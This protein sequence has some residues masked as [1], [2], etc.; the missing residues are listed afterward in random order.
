MTDNEYKLH[1]TM[2]AAM[3]SPLIM[4]N[5]VT[6][7]DAATY[8]I[9]TNP[10]ILAI[11]QDPLGATI[12]RR[13]RYFVPHQDT[14]GVGEI[15]M[16]AG[17]LANGDWVVVLINAATC[18]Y[19]M[20]ATA[21]D[22]FIDNGGAKSTEAMSNWDVYDLWANRMPPAVAN[23]ILNANS[24]VNI[25]NVDTYLYNATAMSYADGIM[26]NHTTLMGKMVSRGPSLQLFDRRS[27]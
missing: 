11:S 22:I 1:M 18:E 2:W 14:Y 17:N 21:T 25:A 23:Q 26:A 12:E 13:W 4:G 15:Q 8:S 20:N 7:M 24:T 9:L 27:C 19:H 5:D 6:S 10:A 16:H 3:K